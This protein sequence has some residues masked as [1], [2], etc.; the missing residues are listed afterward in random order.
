MV[1]NSKGSSKG[2]H[3]GKLLG[4]PKLSIIN[5]VSLLKVFENLEVMQNML[6]Q[7]LHA[8]VPNTPY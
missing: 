4:A 7:K 6:M 2:P 3:K 8:W 1:D 5:H